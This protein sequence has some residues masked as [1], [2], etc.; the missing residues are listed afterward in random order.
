MN[1]VRFEDS[2][3]SVGERVRPRIEQARQKLGRLDGRIKSLLHE[4]PAACLVGALA[5]GYVVARLARR[6]S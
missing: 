4:H 6:R 1:T 5:L 3:D 2:I